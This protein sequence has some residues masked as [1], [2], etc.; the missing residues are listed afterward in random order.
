MKKFFLVMLAAA[1]MAAASCERSF[2]EGNVAF[3]GE[4]KVSVNIGFPMMQTRAYSDGTTATALQYAVFEKKDDVLTKLDSYTVLDETINISK[5]ID[6]QLVT[7]RTYQ[8][9][10]WAAA[11]SEENGWKS[12]YTVEF[13]Q[14]GATMTVDYSAID[15]N[16][17]RNDAFFASV[18][19]EIT[20]DVQMSVELTRPFAQINVGTSDYDI[21]AGQKCAPDL[22]QITLNKAYQELDLVTKVASNPTTDATTFKFNKIDTGEKFPV[23]GYDYLAMIYVLASTDEEADYTVTFSYK[24]G[25]TGEPVDRTVGS[26]PLKRNH[27][28]NLFGQVLTSTA[29]VN[30]I[31]VPEYDEP[32]YNY[33]Q[34]L[35]AAAVGGTAVLEDDVDL[36]DVLIFERDAVVDLNGKTINSPDGKDGAITVL[37]SNLTITGN[38]T[39][40]A[41]D[42]DHCTL[43]WADNGGTVTIENGTFTADGNDDQLIYVGPNGGTI[44]IKGGT[45]RINDD[46]N[47]TLNCYDAAFRSGIAKFVVTGGTFYKFDP[48]HSTAD[49]LS[50]ESYV[51]W[52]A[53]G[54]KSVKTTIE[55]EDWYVVVAEETVVASSAAELA[56]AVQTEGA[57]VQ[58]MPGNYTFSKFAENVTIIGSEGT[59]CTVTGN[60][61]MKNGATFKNVK[62][63]YP[64]TG[65]YPGFT[66]C[67]N[68]TYENCEFEGQPFS[69]A[70]NAVYKNCTFNQTNDAYN[71]WAYTSNPL[72]FEGCTFNCAGKA[73]LIYNEGG[74]KNQEVNIKDCKFYA[75]QAVSGKAAIEISSQ[76]HSVEVHID[77]CTA[78]GFGAG[79]VSNETLWNCKDSTNPV[80]IYV[81]GKEVFKK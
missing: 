78:E 17:E 49:Y 65:Y 63:D 19:K 38:G 39:M 18:E 7:G 64:T 13:T 67:A 22:S 77:N 25:E 54:Y 71:I 31:I 5:Q 11:P 33:S 27:R 23:Q 73:L 48:S 51:N 74:Q 40:Q 28:T 47:F 12:P 79:S 29:S 3:G 24:E 37:G 1:G 76:F 59:V 16:E 44:Y 36:D 53:P 45:F 58:L 43:I 6:F 9:V 50:G 81:D 30:V 57:T 21:A 20:G 26:V 68:L 61:G 60:N 56:E 34:L 41:T 75:S 69:Y 2:D 72:T 46:P 14:T 80:T 52:V 42:D 66:G 35:F 8:F 55:G 62:F 10:F 4:A 70:A 15:A 32:D